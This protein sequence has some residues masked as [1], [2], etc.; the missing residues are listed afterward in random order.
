MDEKQEY[1]NSNKSQKII[2][3]HYDLGWKADRQL[4][5][6]EDEIACLYFKG[7]RG[8]SVHGGVKQINFDNFLVAVLYAQ[9]PGTKA[10]D[11][12]VWSLI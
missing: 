7:S 9:L 3:T 1:E 6:I 10:V 8:H 11:H 2:S 12:T 5:R 4:C